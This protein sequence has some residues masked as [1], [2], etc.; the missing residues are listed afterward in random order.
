[1]A[2]VH[3][4]ETHS[5]TMSRIK[6]EYHNNHFVSQAYIKII[7]PKKYFPVKEILQYHFWT[8][9]LRV[10]NKKTKRTYRAI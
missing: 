6:M 3:S 9:Y 7:L 10:D 1:M 5:Y 8:W 2:D 4:K